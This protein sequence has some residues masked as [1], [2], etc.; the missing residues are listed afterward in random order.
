MKNNSW[1]KA[2]LPGQ[3]KNSKNASQESSKVRMND[4]LCLRFFGVCLLALAVLFGFTVSSFPVAQAQATAPSNLDFGTVV[5]GSS[6]SNSA[7]FPNNNRSVVTSTVSIGGANAGEFSASGCNNV[8]VNPLASCTVN[9]TFKPTSPGS[10]TATLNLTYSTAIGVLTSFKVNLTGVGAVP[11]SP[12]PSISPVSTVSP[13]NSE[14]SGLV[15]LD[16]AP[17]PGF[18]V[19]LEG[20]ETS[21]TTTGGDGRYSFKGLPEGAY[22]VRVPFDNTKYTVVGQN[23]SNQTMTGTSVENRINFQFNSIAQPTTPPAT[24]SPGGQPSF[25]PTLTVTPKSGPPGTLVTIT[26]TGWNP[27]GPDGGQNQVLVTLE[28]STG[29]GSGSLSSF[30]LSKASASLVTLGSFPV[31]SDGTINAQATLPALVPQ[32]VLVLAKDRNSQNAQAPFAVVGAADVVCPNVPAGSKLRVGTASAQ[33][34][35]NTFK[36]CVVVTASVNEGVNLTDSLIITLPNGSGVTNSSVSAGTVTVTNNSVDWGGFTLAAG[37]SANLILTINSPSG[38]LNGTSLFISGRFNRGQAF[39][40][41][42]PGLIPLTEIDVPQATAVI[43]QGAPSTGSGAAA[44]QDNFG[45]PFLL[46]AATLLGAF[47]LIAGWKLIKRG[48]QR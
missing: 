9:V 10:K 40:Q 24:T 30:S 44:T 34:G 17:A 4:G 25:N 45:Y 5:V 7:S 33:T 46:L 27:K 42:I 14:I 39:Q 21:Q 3:L 38:S 29:S 26:G 47:W 13:S 16:G 12:S 36:I 23:F 48:R 41:R 28:S 19:K 8:S 22:V 11:P 2:H 37:Q 1:R 35:P 20:R 15:T 32:N 6:S 18:M 43:P 31:N